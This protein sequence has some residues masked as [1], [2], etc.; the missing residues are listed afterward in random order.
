[1]LGL[2]LSGGGG[3][4]LPFTGGGAVGGGGIWGFQKEVK[5]EV[6]YLALAGGALQERDRDIFNV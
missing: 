6:G 5:E 4:L 2:E 3:T 1:M